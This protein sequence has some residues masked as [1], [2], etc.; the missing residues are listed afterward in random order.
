MDYPIVGLKLELSDR[1]KASHF[2]EED[3][4]KVIH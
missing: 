2:K 3:F 1:E 4:I